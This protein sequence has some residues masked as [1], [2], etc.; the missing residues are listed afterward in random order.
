MVMKQSEELLWKYIDG[1]C[2]EQEQRWVANQLEA[3]TNYKAL[4]QSLLQFNQQLKE[5]IELQEP[6]FAFTA[7][8]MR[9]IEAQNEVVPL[10]TK[11]NT[12]LIVAFVGCLAVAFVAVA[13]YWLLVP[14]QPSWLSDYIGSEWKL[15][16]P[17]INRTVLYT[18]LAL[19]YSAILLL[20]VDR[21]LRNRLSQ[22]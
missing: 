12:K 8:L 18:A 7:N 19:T 6:S 14:S 22:K 5:N 15:R 9:E 10:K 17:E 1:T 4:Y 13:V 11:V 20:F 2:N 16:L 21:V 3:D